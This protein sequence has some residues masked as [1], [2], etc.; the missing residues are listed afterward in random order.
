MNRSAFIEVLKQT[1]HEW[2]VDKV[3]RLGAALAY[4]SVFSIAPLVLLSV[5]IAGLAFGEQ[6]ARGQIAGQIEGAVG[7]TSARAI[8]DMIQHTSDPRAG[9]TATVVGLI[10]LALRQVR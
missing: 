8:E 4:Y 7:E 9:L 1:F 3:P 10:I 2:S 6:A 5:A